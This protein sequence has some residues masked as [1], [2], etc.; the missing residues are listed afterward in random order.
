[1]Q[2]TKCAFNHPGC[3][4]TE[5][6]PVAKQKWF[7]LLAK[8]CCPACLGIEADRAINNRDR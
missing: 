3:A 2:L 6:E 4:K 5:R 8:D 1:M 7:T